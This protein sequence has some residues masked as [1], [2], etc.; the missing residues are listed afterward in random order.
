[1]R[2]NSRQWSVLFLVLAVLFGGMVRFV[3]AVLGRFP[4]NDGGMFFTMIGDLRANGFALPAS[5]TYNHLNIPFAYPPLS[6]YVGAWLSALGISTMEV[7]RWMPAVVSTLSIPAFYWMAAQT[8]GSRP[9]AALST[10]AYALMPRSFSWYVMGGGLSRGLGMLFL[11]LTCGAV[12]SMFSKP[13]WRTTLLAAVCGAGA[14]LSHPETGLHTLAAC[15]L[16]W[17]FRGRSLAG[18]RSAAAVGAGVLVLTSPW[19]L[20]VLI[21]NGFPTIQSALNA[22]G[23]SPYFWVAWLTLDF[24]EERFVTWLTVL[25]LIGFAVQC[26]KRQWFLP[27]WLLFPFAVEPRSATAIAAVPL[28]VLAGIGLAEFLIPG[29]YV[30]ASGARADTDWTLPFSKSGAVRAVTGYIVL[31]ALAGAISYDLALAQYVV[32]ATSRQAMQWVQANTA[33]AARFLVL[34]GHSD[35][36]SDP[37]AEWFPALAQ[38]TSSNTIQGQEWT[39][40]RRFMPFLDGVTE[41]QSC[42]NSAPTC[43]DEWEASQGI[44]FDYVFLQA[45]DRSATTTSGLLLFQL[46]QDANYSLIYENPGVEIFARR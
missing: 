7:L 42:V 3:P 24:A 1:M 38:R 32:P 11:L 4:I 35:P 26:L 6:L 25:G 21:N 9:T 12:W 46:K 27:A 15:L 19:W 39:L 41:L 13:G 31:A 5:T 45:L 18:V 28:A 37:T 29:M 43:V 23:H 16:I 8:L 2:D 30:L 17:L 34:T 20:A 44:G 22:G 36:F 40:G 14:V 10:V 33:P